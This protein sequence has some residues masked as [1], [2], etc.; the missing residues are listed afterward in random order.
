MVKL[1]VKLMVNLMMRALGQVD[2]GKRLETPYFS[3]KDHNFA[4]NRAENHRYE[5]LLHLF[6]VYRSEGQRDAGIARST[7]LYT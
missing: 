1:M 2:A 6:Q 7:C 3:T 5:N 4:L